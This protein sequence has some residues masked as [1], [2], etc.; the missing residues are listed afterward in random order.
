M[1]DLRISE[2]ETLNVVPAEPLWIVV[3]HDGTNKK[4]KASVLLGS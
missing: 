1:P 2:L 4:I 3:V